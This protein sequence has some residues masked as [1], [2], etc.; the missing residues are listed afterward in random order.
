MCIRDRYWVGNDNYLLASSSG[1]INKPI[2]LSSRKYL[3]YPNKNFGKIIFSSPIVGVISN[4]NILPI[5]LT[6]TS[7]KGYVVG[8]SVLSVQIKELLTKLSQFKTPNEEFMILSQN[9]ILLS[10]YEDFQKIINQDKLSFSATKWQIIFSFF[11]NKNKEFLLFEEK[12][13]DFSIVIAVKRQ[14]FVDEM[15]NIMLPY[16]VQAINIILL[17]FFL[18]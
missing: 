2:D 4:E 12:S 5:S 14:Y 13:E 3:D 16:L 10:S 18:R 7:E 6:L 11:S 8:T 1:K 15:K 17:L 9:N